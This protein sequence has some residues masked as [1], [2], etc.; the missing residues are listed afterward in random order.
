MHYAAVNSE[1]KRIAVSDWAEACT[2]YV[3]RVLRSGAELGLRERRDVQAGSEVASSCH[4][5]PRGAPRA[6][7]TS[8]G[9]AEEGV[10]IPN[11]DEECGNRK[12]H[13]SDQ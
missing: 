13:W 7:P 8:G 2:Q 12:S 5:V 11:L 3:C 9:I 4:P 1:W 10:N 6:E